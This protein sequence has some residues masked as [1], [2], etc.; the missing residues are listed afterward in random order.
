MLSAALLL[1]PLAAAAIE[2]FTPAQILDWE[3]HSF[4]GST[5]YALADT[6]NGPAVHARC[7]GGSASGLFYRGEIDLTETPVV[8]WRW[9]AGQRP[10]DVDERSRAGDDFAARL[11]AVDEH[12]I[13]RW[14]TRALNYVWSAGEPVGSHWPN[15]FASQ[16]RMIAV[17][18]GEPD[19]EG[20]VVHRRNL[21]EDFRR[22]HDRDLTELDALA[23]MTDC[24]NTGEPTEAWYGRIRLLPAG[25]G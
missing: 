2:R 18:S 13:L 23:I 4:T 6:A 12:T 10:Q 11:Y 3:P 16:A 8:E 15:P 5:R 7:E 19:S 14:R 21:R 20:W 1:L 25:A 22:Y 17:A 9:R 24:D